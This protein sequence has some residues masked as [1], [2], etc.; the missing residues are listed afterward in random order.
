MA[1]G[2][3]SVALPL[4]QH[5]NSA[6]RTLAKTPI[7]GQYFLDGNQSLQDTG[8]TPVSPLADAADGNPATS[9]IATGTPDY[10]V[11]FSIRGTATPLTDLISGGFI[12]SAEA[13]MQASIIGTGGIGLTQFFISMPFTFYELNEGGLNQWWAF[14]QADLDNLTS[15][16]TDLNFNLN[17]FQSGAQVPGQVQVRRALFKVTETMV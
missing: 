10:N 13:M 14:G 2:G 8:T 7:E 17:T 15:F 5:L 9:A 11:N 1:L 16:N 12:A 6:S 3:G 4:N